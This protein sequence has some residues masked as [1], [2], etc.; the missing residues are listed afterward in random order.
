MP[1]RITADSVFRDNL[2]PLNC[3]RHPAHSDSPLHSHEFH[4]LVIV[5][6]GHGLHRTRTEEYPIEAGLVFLIRDRMEHG[7]ANVKDLSLVNVLFDP[8]RL[9]LPMALLRD[10]PGYHALFR[11]EPRL[12]RHT[13]AQ[14]RLQLTQEEL[15][16]VAG[17][18]DRLHDEL[19]RRTPGYRF[20]ACAY[21]MTLLTFVSRCYSHADR[22]PERPLL[23]MGEVLR[24]ID[25][26]Y[27][28]PITIAQ[29]TKR[30]H[31]SES[32]L[33]RTFRRVLNRSPIE[34]V[35]RV[36]I[37]KAADLLRHGDVRITEAAF[38]CG[39]SDSNYFSRQ[40]RRIMGLSPRAY[41]ARHVPPAR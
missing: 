11:I 4:E 33:M 22:H 26:H 28:E 6:A 36:R 13:R 35:I 9:D 5:L 14:G 16:E 7:Y 12:R 21:L 19:H 34:H 40:F 17:M 29:L 20:Q 18:V 31:M 8:S 2:L 38:E 23:H 32:S 39:F 1:H 10:L 37:Q 25:Q 30:A 24:F 41:R 3:Q 27:D 15:S